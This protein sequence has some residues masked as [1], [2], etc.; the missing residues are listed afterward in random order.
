MRRV[1]C[2]T[3]PTRVPWD[4]YEAFAR[5]GVD[6]LCAGDFEGPRALRDYFQ[7]T[8][9]GD[10][11][12][13]DDKLEVGFDPF[14][15]AP[16][17]RIEGVIGDIMAESSDGAP[18]LSGMLL[19]WDNG[20][21]LF[22]IYAYSGVFPPDIETYRWTYAYLRHDARRAVVTSPC[23]TRDPDSFWKL[24]IRKEWAKG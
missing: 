5:Q 19:L 23:N 21:S 1:R 12:L 13:Y 15:I 24:D 14:P 2:E 20:N 10:V 11:W 4:A 8:T 9:W 17:P 16:P 22:E 3:P 6:M 7:T 18:P